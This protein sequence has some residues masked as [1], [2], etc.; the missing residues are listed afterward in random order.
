MK[1]ANTDKENQFM[2]AA[3]TAAA[4]AAVNPQAE[5]EPMAVDFVNIFFCFYGI[6]Y[7]VMLTVSLQGQHMLF[8]SH[9]QCF[10]TWLGERKGV[11]FVKILC[12]LFPKVEKEI[13][14]QLHNGVLSV[15]IFH[16]VD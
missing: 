4:A 10:D 16:I 15:S 6:I 11:W 1:R 9:L 8:L 7:A 2:A 12:R 13:Q 14:V 5:E 3:A